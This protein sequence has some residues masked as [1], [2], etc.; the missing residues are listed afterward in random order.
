MKLLAGSLAFPAR[1]PGLY[2][3]FNPYTFR[4]ERVPTAYR[5]GPFVYVVGTIFGRK[6]Y[7]LKL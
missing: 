7:G 6:V 5:T 1:R 2:K 3:S 4:H